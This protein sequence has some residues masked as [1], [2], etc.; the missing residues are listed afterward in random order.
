MTLLILLLYDINI[1]G[2]HEDIRAY[3][4]KSAIGHYI[5]T[6][7]LRQP[8]VPLSHRITLTDLR[9]ELHPQRLRVSGAAGTHLL[10]RRVLLVPIYV[11]DFRLEDARYALV[12]ELYPPKAS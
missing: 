2:A 6:P 9:V 5:I 1:F 7:F 8:R 10:V 11:T 4:T 12:R 3:K